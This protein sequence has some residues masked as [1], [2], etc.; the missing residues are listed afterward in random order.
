MKTPSPR[1]TCLLGLALV[2]ALAPLAHRAPERLDTSSHIDGSEA[3]AVEQALVE[4]FES[5]FARV[6]V[7]VVTGVPAP[8]LPAG[9][10]ALEDVVAGLASTPGVIGT[11]SYLDV[12]DPLFLPDHH[13][14][15]RRDGTFV[16]VGI[17]PGLP[18]D[19]IVPRLRTAAA[20]IDARIRRRHP[21]A[22]LLFTGEASL[23][24]DL[25]RASGDE[26]AA[27]EARALPL[28]VALLLL[29][30]GSVP[31]SVLSACAGVASVTV[32]MALAGLL[33][34]LVPLSLSLQSVVSMLGLGLG[35]DYALLVASRF[36]E[37]L[38]DGRGSREAAREAARH[39]GGGRWRSPAPAWRS[40]SRPCS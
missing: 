19:R 23:N 9:R 25:R 40:V 38:A 6:E 11:F 26:V 31:A 17:E 24:F 37:S 27:A 12:R 13:P 21:E 30:F 3:T 8:D 20:G 1:L 7:A 29:A 32:S 28:T 5:P 15:G 35:I 18:P 2:A 10:E 22:R 34:S 16:A 14:G 36:R 4:R 33:T 39:A